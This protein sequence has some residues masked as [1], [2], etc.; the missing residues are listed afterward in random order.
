MKYRY[1]IDE[2]IGQLKFDKL[3]GNHRPD[4]LVKRTKTGKQK[5]VGS[6]IIRQRGMKPGMFRRKT[7]SG[8]SLPSDEWYE[9]IA[10][11]KDEETVPHEGFHNTMKIIEDRF[12]KKVADG[13]IQKLISYIPRKTKGELTYMLSAVRSYMTSTNKYNEEIINIIHD[14]LSDKK[15][16][17]DGTGSSA[18]SHYIKSIIQLNDIDPSDEASI[19]EIIHYKIAELKKIWK[20]MLKFSKQLV[21]DKKDIKPKYRHEPIN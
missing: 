12:G 20:E 4:S 10:F 1:K 16:N 3:L 7:V 2:S 19:L 11:A 15:Y 5:R 8:V 14:I 13:I 21:V 9:P 17:I 6:Q 18:R